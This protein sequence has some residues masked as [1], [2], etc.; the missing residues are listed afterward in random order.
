[1]KVQPRDIENF[2]KNPPKNI[3]A[4]LIYGPD[5]GLARERLNKFT[6]NVVP[7]LQDPFNI[8]DINSSTLNENPALLSDEVLSISMLGGRK[9]VR[10]REASDK[11][12]S[13]I[14]S[15]AASLNSD[16]NFLLIEAGELSPRSSLRL[17]FEGEDNVAAIP[18]YVE[19]ERDLSRVIAEALREAGYNFNSDVTNYVAA[20]VVG[21]RGIARSEIQKLIT[22][23]G[24]NKNITLEDAQ[25]CIGN[26][27]DLSLDDVA[28]LVASGKF[29]EADRIVAHL[30]SEGISAVAVLRS[31]Q[32]YFDKL[33]ITKS[34][35]EQGEPLD[36]AVKKLKPPL[37]FKAKAAFEAHVRNWSIS[38]LEQAINI[39]I[40]AE[41][42]CKQTASRPET[43][44]S[45]A[46]LSIAQMGSKS[47]GR[48]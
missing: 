34:R 35:I 40:S 28:K 4:V 10:L 30:L 39:I 38:S 22:Y 1:M 18:C 26:S 29:A 43:I 31:M 6:T 33:F 16:C 42:K 3:C 36:S 47:M 20:N 21:D 23:M 11:N 12:T 27:A 2:V 48:R 44:C 8:V 13:T 45:R 37:F 7:D 24:D 32:S 9:V 41:A 46:V 17:L 19:D 25:A 5:E 15:V 14:K